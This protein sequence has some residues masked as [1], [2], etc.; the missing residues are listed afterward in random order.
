MPITGAG[1]A[2]L[3]TLPA[4]EEL[5]CNLKHDADDG[6]VHIGKCPQ[7][8]KLGIGESTVTDRGLWSLRGLKNLEWLDLCSTSI[9]EGIGVAQHFPKL[10]TLLLE[11]TCV[12]DEGLEV[13]GRLPLLE[14]LTLG[15]TH[16]SDDGIGQLREL[17]TLKTLALRGIPV[18]AAGIQH[19]TLLPSLDYL[20]I[21]ETP[22]DDSMLKVFASMRQLRNLCL[23]TGGTDKSRQARLRKALPECEITWL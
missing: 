4:L 2:I 8:R 22:I 7:L 12:S 19:L 20:L 13:V 14:E 15:S 5:H 6:L 3:P 23:K 11:D 10:R 18:T 21:W 1:L 9:S 17:R 16:I